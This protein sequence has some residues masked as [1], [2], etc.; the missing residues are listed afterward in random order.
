MRFIFTA[1]LL[2]FLHVNSFVSGQGKPSWSY[3]INPYYGGV[4]RYKEDMPKLD[5]TG[6]HG[7]ELYTVKMT[8]GKHRWEKLY[9]YPHIGFA[10]SYFNYGVPDE[11]G[12]VYSLASYM[13]VTANNRKKFQ[14][15][16]NIGTGFVYSTKRFDAQTNPDNKAISSRISYVLRGTIHHE[17]QL[18]EQYY[19]N[20]N[21]AFRHYSNGKLNIPNNGMNFPVVG[22]GLRYVPNP[23]KI[24]FKKDTTSAFNKKLLINLM[25]G[26]AWR[27]VLRE[28]YKQKA[29][30]AS[31]YLSKQ[32]TRYNTLLLGVDGFLYDKE[33][34]RKA[35]QVYNTQNT[36]VPEDQLVDDD[37]KQMAV[38][39]GTELLFGKLSVILQGGA[40]VYKPQIYYEATWYQRY[41]FKYQV[42]PYLFPQVTLKSHSRTADMVEFGLGVSF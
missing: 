37:G 19:F 26:T 1:L 16:L 10:A 7:I 22:V 3:G 30:S 28:D 25:G 24:D 18:S 38:T 34:V 2:V 4:L 32:I 39:I 31:L 35:T 21:L 33:S 29:Y 14:W 12:E 20:L 40:Y 15:R 8:N 6:L 41:G 27:E 23:Q 36:A 5:M 13:D 42:T 17:I 9:N 11:L